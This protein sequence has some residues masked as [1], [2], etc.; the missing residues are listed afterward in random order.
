ME[1][2]NKKESRLKFYVVTELDGRE[3]KKGKFKRF[4]ISKYWQMN[5]KH[6]QGK[7]TINFILAKNFLELKNKIIKADKNSVVIFDEGER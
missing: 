1:K 7:P 4:R 6:L 2:P 3:I 5:L